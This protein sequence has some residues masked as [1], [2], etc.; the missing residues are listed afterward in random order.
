M[1]EIILRSSRPAGQANGLT[2]DE[3]DGNFTALNNELGEK[4]DILVSGETIK[5]VNGSSLLGSGDIE[6]E[7]KSAYQVALDAGFV[8]TEQEW[9]DSLRGEN[10][11]SFTVDVVGEFASRSTYDDEPEG[12]S[13]LATDT[14]EIYFRTGAAGTWTPGVPFG[15]GP[16]GNDGPPG[17][18]GENGTDGANGDNGEP[19]TDGREIQMSASATHIQWRYVGDPDW[20]D[21]LPLTE[22][23]GPQGVPGQNI[24]LQKSATHI[25]WRVVGTPT[26]VNLVPLA[27]LKGDPGAKGDKGDV[28]TSA[29]ALPIVLVSSMTPSSGSNYILAANTLYI[30]DVQNCRL[31]IPQ[32]MAIGARIGFSEALASGQTYQIN[33]GTVP[34][35]GVVHGIATLTSAHGST[36]WR[37]VSQEKGLI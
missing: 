19:G 6:I 32:N 35:R 30:V 1:A 12:F 18:P 17:P 31:D 10:G 5:T 26:W 11:E 22:I 37:N 16:Q 3:I 2:N 20:I 8:G 36:Q 24:E 25:Q 28:D 27:D 29:A 23:Q 4:Q 34:L 14:S 15:R 33:F 9:L 13:F 7:G 21:L